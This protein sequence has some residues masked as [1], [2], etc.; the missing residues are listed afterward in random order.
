MK[1]SAAI[2]F[3]LFL[4][5]LL[6]T[7][8]GGQ[9]VNYPESEDYVLAGVETSN[10]SSALDNYLEPS[11]Q[12]SSK[13]D[14]S[15]DMQG[16]ILPVR[17]MYIAVLQNNAEFFEH[18]NIINSYLQRI[19]ESKN[20]GVYVKLSESLYMRAGFPLEIERFTL[21]YVENSDIPAVVLHLRDTGGERLLLH[22]DNGMVYGYNFSYRGL[23]LLKRDGTAWSS[24]GTIGGSIRLR[25]YAG[26]IESVAVSI[27]DF[28]AGDLTIPPIFYVY[29]E[30]VS[31]DVFRAIRDAHNDKED[32]PWYAFSAESIAV[33]FALAWNNFF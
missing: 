30:E 10:S 28:H 19:D 18:T 2:F 29:G 8:C 26:F 3:A 23:F 14:K 20:Q 6:L 7:A 24:G 17:D 9:S 12:N 13:D 16:Y 25:F 5:A 1:K 27:A 33:D 11:E 22:Y 31:E 4:A 32:A 21:V 15:S